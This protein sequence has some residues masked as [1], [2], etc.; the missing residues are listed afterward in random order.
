MKQK[1]ILK[2][3][4][5]WS[6]AFFILFGTSFC[7]T[8]SK[9]DIKEAKT[10][11]SV[12]ENIP[13]SS[14]AIAE[15]KL[16]EIKEDDVIGVWKPEKEDYKVEIYK[17][18]TEFSGKIVWM[19]EANS[20][21]GEPILDKLNPQRNRRA[22][23]ILGL[24][25]VERF[26]FNNYDKSWEDGMIYNPMTGETMKCTIN[27]LDKNTIELVGFVGFSL[28]EVKVLWKRVDVE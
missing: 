24:E 20:K 21:N 28:S 2:S 26:E 23:P 17:N 8:V 5:F 4:I 18:D 25:V 15:V 27:M 6:F 9:D 1:P 19:K 12:T 22:Q 16:S 13:S 3:S 10:T 14:E 11:Q 7:K